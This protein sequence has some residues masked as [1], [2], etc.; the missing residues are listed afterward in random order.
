MD[1][2][3]DLDRPQRKQPLQRTIMNGSPTLPLFLALACLGSAT[4]AQTAAPKG[5]AVQFVRDV[6]PILRDKCVFCH[7]PSVQQAG[8]RL[9]TR[10]EMLRGG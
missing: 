10:I 7:G 1:S 2:Q 3:F 8:L 4:F 9:D 5:S 6:V